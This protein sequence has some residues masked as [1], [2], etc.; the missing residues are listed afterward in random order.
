MLSKSES[1]S[2]DVHVAEH[3]SPGAVLPSS[4]SSGNSRT[5]LPQKAPPASISQM[6]S[7]LRFYYHIILKKAILADIK[8]PKLE[9]KE[10]SRT[11][12]KN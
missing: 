3:P 11:R 7:A 10:H 5:P 8:T 6:L 12:V 1:P 9:K 2:S 4:H